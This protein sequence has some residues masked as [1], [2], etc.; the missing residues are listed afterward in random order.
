MRAL[1]PRQT[2][3][4]LTGLN[5]FNYFDR[6]VLSAVLHSIQVDWGIS[7]SKAGWLGT[8]FMLGYF[9]T[10]PFFGWLG[11]RTSRKW[12]I[13][14]GIL[15][16]SAATIMTGF[17]G[18]FTVMLCWR[19]MVG[20]GEASYATVSPAWLSDVY[21]PEKRNTA[22]TWFYTAIP[23]GAAIGTL[24]GGFIAKHQGWQHAFI[25]AGA[26]GLLLALLL[27]PFKEP[28]RTT[29]GAPGEHR[30]PGMK[31]IGALLR[32]PD[33]NLSVWGYTAYTF[34]L[35]AMAHWGPSFLQRAHGM[36]QQEAGGFFGPMLA[37]AGLGGTLIG[38]LAATAWRKRH[39]SGYAGVLAASMLL[40]APAAWLAFTAPDRTVSMVAL[41]V[42]MFCCFL[43]TGPINTLIL[44]CSPA[45]LRASAMAGS[46]FIIHLFGDLWSPWVVGELSDHWKNFS[47]ALLILPVALFIAGVLW[48]ILAWKQHLTPREDHGMA[49]SPA[50]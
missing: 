41:A 31:D 5:L 15:V 35:G 33:Y 30:L 1:T 39:R 9:V 46:I 3:I 16:W 21:P 8:A 49:K 11:D 32:R 14:G 34:A 28:A 22:L 6:Y 50:V 47:H 40:G 24:M 37:V 10:A 43:G 38:G 25:W 18:S 26:P 44:E 23:I 19:V 29:D 27:L 17:A 12:L 13:A 20:V 48:A 7:D 4:I 45:T 2:L 36:T 42:S